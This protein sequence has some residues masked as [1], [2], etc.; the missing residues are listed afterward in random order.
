MK[1]LRVL[2]HNSVNR[3]WTLD[4]SGIPRRFPISSG[5]V[6]TKFRSLK[7]QQFS[8]TSGGFKFYPWKN[9]HS[10]WNFPDISVIV[11]L[12]LQS[13]FRTR[14]FLGTKFQNIAFL[15]EV[16]LKFYQNFALLCVL[17]FNEKLFTLG[18]NFS[19]KIQRYFVV[20]KLSQLITCR[21]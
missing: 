19:K 1:K 21:T 2:I 4:V 7:L 18:N 5:F 11:R 12:N 14:Y 10:W 8:L 17:A 6:L 9:F 13:N 15:L 16:L 3:L 20:L